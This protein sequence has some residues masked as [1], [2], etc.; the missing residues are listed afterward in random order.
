MREAIKE[1]TSTTVHEYALVQNGTSA[2][3][4]GN[5]FRIFMVQLGA[6]KTVPP[7]CARP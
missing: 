2:T 7:K 1:V 3:L 6:S 5:A 4:H